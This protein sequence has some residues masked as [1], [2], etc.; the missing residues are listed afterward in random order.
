[1]VLATVI[2]G[3]IGLVLFVITEAKQQAPLMPVD[4]FRSK[5]FSGANLLTLF[6]YAALSGALFFV[7]FNLIQVQGYSPVEAGSALLP[8]PIIMF[9]LSRWA[10]GLVSRYDARLPLTVGPLVAGLGFLL[11][12]LPDVGGSYWYTCFPAIS[13]LGLGMAISVAP[14]TATVMG[15]VSADRSGAASGINNAVARLAGLLAIAL[16]GLS[17][18][19]A[20]SAKLNQHITA[21]SLPAS[22]QEAVKQQHSQLAAIEIPSSLDA[23]LRTQVQHAIDESFVS[24][25]RE[26]VLICAA[27]A[28][29]SGLTAALTI[30]HR[31]KKI[32][33]SKKTA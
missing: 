15:S 1:M 30:T 23:S 6:L 2:G 19:S 27:L 9:L 10:G 26:V 16:L 17:I 31:Q 21:L 22:L 33:N 28:F 13:V 24:A 12:A 18:Q 14:L 7:P 8:F 3:A 20:F 11:F 32:H 29:V 4:V 25:F 5:N